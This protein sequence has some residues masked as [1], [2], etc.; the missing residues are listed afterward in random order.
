MEGL[1]ATVKSLDSVETG[2]PQQLFLS[3]TVTSSKLYELN[4]TDNPQRAL[5]TLFP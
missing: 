3:S 2:K 5:K 4:S 1:G